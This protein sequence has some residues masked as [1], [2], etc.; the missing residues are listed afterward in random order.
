MIEIT[1]TTIYQLFGAS[2]YY[3]NIGHQV[4][5]KQGMISNDYLQH[6]KIMRI[7]FFTI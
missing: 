5:P 3:H 2:G 7:G 4:S 6:F 1:R